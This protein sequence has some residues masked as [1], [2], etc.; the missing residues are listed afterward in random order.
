MSWN[1]G[2]M[3][4]V[5]VV[6]MLIL[7]YT[8]LIVLGP[9]SQ[10][11]DVRRLA[12]WATLAGA[13]F[14]ALLL[15]G[16]GLFIVTKWMD[17]AAIRNGTY[18]RYV[19]NAARTAIQSMPST[20]S[21]ARASAPVGALGEGKG[22][23]TG[24]AVHTVG[25][26]AIQ[27]DQIVLGRELRGD[28]ELIVAD[29]AN[30]FIHCAITGETGRGKTTAVLWFLVQLVTREIDVYILDP[31][32]RD[33]CHKTGRDVTAIRM[34]AAKVAYEMDDIDKTL[35][36][37]ETEL[38]HRREMVRSGRQYGNPV[39]CVV[40][41]TTRIGRA[42]PTFM[43]RMLAIIEE[44]RQY[45][46]F[47]LCACHNLLVGDNKGVHGAFRQNFT[48]YIY[49][50]GDPTTAAK[51]FGMA[52]REVTLAMQALPEGPG[53][54]LV[55]VGK[56][57]MAMK[58]PLIT[59][60]TLRRVPPKTRV[61]ISSGRAGEGVKEHEIVPLHRPSPIPFTVKGI[62]PPARTYAPSRPLHYGEGVKDVKEGEG[63]G[64]KD[65]EGDDECT[66]GRVEQYAREC[67]EA[68]WSNYQ[69]A[70]YV[71]KVEGGK[72]YREC[73]G[74]INRLRGEVGG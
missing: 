22:L 36:E 47:V 32:Y 6:S 65:G 73:V 54:A 64:V 15:I 9:S 27:A 10:H 37:V 51:M 45:D 20:A 11:E 57:V 50:G 8:L 28:G 70:R 40:D 35:L 30:E 14:L 41:E 59:N 25:R 72:R 49:L 56:R 58:I 55:K 60:E 44:G 67:I 26:Q 53:Y 34:A 17:A 52:E 48:T 19:E 24:A 46:V 21:A 5:F 74:V 61:S 38:Q 16:L 68:G 12:A 23:N 33:V 42:V 4:G 3:E 18:G 31:N 13:I 2:T 66:Y 71:Y 63:E 1:R 69:I 62:N 29:I 39:Y 7:G 43:K